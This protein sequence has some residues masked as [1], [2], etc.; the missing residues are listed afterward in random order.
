[1]APV[2][3]AVAVAVAVAAVVV[4][5]VAAVAVGAPAESVSV[6]GSRVP[7]VEPATWETAATAQRAE[8]ATKVR[9]FRM[10]LRA[11]HFRSP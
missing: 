10:V 7:A 1:M 8:S 3:V 4:A 2:V 6:Q 9:C 11:L 5:A